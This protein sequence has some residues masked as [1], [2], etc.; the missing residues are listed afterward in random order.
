MNKQIIAHSAVIRCGIVIVLL[1]HQNFLMVSL[2][3]SHVSA[4]KFLVPLAA[5]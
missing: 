1:F 2:Y 5:C 3:H 4:E